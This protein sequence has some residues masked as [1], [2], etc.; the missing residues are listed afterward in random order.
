MV[1]A[2]VVSARI[3]PHSEQV[4]NPQPRG[5]CQNVI[6]VIWNLAHISF[7]AVHH[8]GAEV[9]GKAFL[10]PWVQL[11]R[12]GPIHELVRVLME[13]G[14]PGILHRHVEQ[15][16]AAIGAALK[17]TRQFRGLAAP[18]GRKLS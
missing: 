11:H 15:D 8:D 16:E 6:F 13:N 7:L 10:K 12:H 5:V 9:F 3:L 4:D 2:L 18:D 1:A 14:L 17:Q